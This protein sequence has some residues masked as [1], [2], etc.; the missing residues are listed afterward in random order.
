M[1][2]RTETDFLGEK[3]IPANALWGTHAARAF[4]NFPR[5]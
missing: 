4:E 3:K 2:F 5:V 1:E